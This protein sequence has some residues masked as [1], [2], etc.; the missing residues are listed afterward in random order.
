MTKN[1][2]FSFV[3]IYFTAFVLSLT[4]VGE[5]QSEDKPLILSRYLVEGE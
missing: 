1:L 3:L 2:I 5:K 4:G